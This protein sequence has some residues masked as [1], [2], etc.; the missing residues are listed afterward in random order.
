MVIGSFYA[1]FYIT[2]LAFVEGEKSKMG[3][4]AGAV[5]VMEAGGK[6]LYILAA[7]PFFLLM[8]LMEM[9]IS[10]VSNL[11]C[12]GGRYSFDDAWS[13]LA[14][15]ITQQM[16]SSLVKVPLK[17]GILPY[18]Y[19]HYTF[20]VPNG[21]NLP[22]DSVG[23]WVGCAL[24]VDLCYYWLHRKSHEWLFLWA[25]HGVHH[26]SEY[27]NLSTALR[28]SWLQVLA[29]PF[30]YLPMALFFPPAL[31]FGLDQAN[32]VYQF[33]VHTCLVRRLGPLEWV[34]MTPSHH[35]VHHDRRLHKNFGGFLIIW[36]R[37]FGSFVD[38]S[39][40][41]RGLERLGD[42]SAPQE[43]VLLFGILP[44]VGTWTEAVTQTQLY[45]PVVKAV[46]SGAGLTGILKACY[47]GPG[48]TTAGAPRSL[49]PPSASA[50]RIRKVSPLPPAARSYVLAQF[51]MVVLVGFAVL[52]SATAPYALRLFTGAT[53]LYSLYCQGVL[54]D[55]EGRKGLHWEGARALL[56]SLLL[57][58]LLLLSP[59][60]F[61]SSFPPPL[62]AALTHQHMRAAMAML[63]GWHVLSMGWLLSI[64]G[65]LPP[66]SSE[67]SAAP[68][69]KTE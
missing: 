29:A 68:S 64:K 67:P 49:V 38:E 15:G 12:V 62:V 33:W 2:P 54:L 9:V 55:G 57:L 24:V 8:I 1:T 69:R 53:V 40:G 35:R 25:G 31:Y 34:L 7:I 28:Q 16:C 46:K 26:S 58:L 27:F 37:M 47:V 17:L 6:T 3:G 41:V 11:Q 18:S 4:Y 10:V 43:E 51:V 60:S 14:A 56:L 52:I 59:A 65:H 5:E 50:Q 66:P 44:K 45:A 48:F 36:D 21:L 23:V 32:I 13:S 20:S 30:F 19:I 63:L 39:E 61:P 22:V 42:S